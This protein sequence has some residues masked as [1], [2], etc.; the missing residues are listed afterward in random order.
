MMPLEISG[1]KV[2]GFDDPVAALEHINL[3]AMTAGCYYLTLEC[4]RCPV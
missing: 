3:D 4:L 1:I 2:H